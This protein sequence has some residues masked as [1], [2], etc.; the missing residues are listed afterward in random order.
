[1]DLLPDEPL[2]DKLLRNGFRLYFF[3]FLI[4]PAGYLLK[5]MVSRSL[6]VADVGIFYSIVGF[7]TIISAY[8]DL[9]LT[10]A[11]QYYL[12]HYFIDKEY[13]KAKTIIVFTWLVQFASAII[14]G[15]WLYLGADR[16]A[17]HYFQSGES[18][19][20]LKY[21][22]LYFLGIN[23]FQV[24][25]S[26]FTALQHVKSQ[27]VIEIVRLR[28]T[29]V[30]VFVAFHY[31]TLTLLSYTQRWLVG[32]AISTGAAMLMIWSQLKWLFI[33]YSF[34]WDYHLLKK[35]W[36]YWLRI[37]LG[38]W[39]GTLFGQINQQF[40]LYFFWPEAAGYWTNYLSLFTMVW[41]ITTPLISY[42]F[43][44]LN[45]LYKKGDV[46]KVTLLYKYLMRWVVAFGIIGAICGYFLSEWVAV[47]LFG[48]AFRMSGTLF[49]H[50]A[51]FIFTLPLIGILFQDIA[52]RGMVKQ[53][54]YAIVFALIGNT[55]ATI[56]LWR[57]F[58]L[59]GIVYAQLLGNLILV[60]YGWYWWKKKL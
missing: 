52:S 39:A 2:K 36:V 4:A 43:P 37:L 50:Y 29:V 25:Q 47:L 48:E 58:G 44:L 15:W 9:W 34:K 32:M 38:I 13:R 33:D 3:Q 18:V 55:I 19:L 51:P 46:E 7:I 8:N 16:L 56:I 49:T 27:Q 57:L 24:I 54:V 41:V 20:L 45:E 5:M 12:P 17:T 30:L 11:L 23:L 53:R 21:F 14:V 6:S 26:V 40:A 35:Q 28:S 1:M 59:T 22:A 31:G 10:E 60:M 42:L